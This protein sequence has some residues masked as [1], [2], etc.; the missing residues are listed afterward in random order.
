MQS[1]QQRGFVLMEVL[2]ALLVIAL[3]LPL[4]G[5]LLHWAV[6]T[7]QVSGALTVESYEARSVMERVVKD[8][9]EA[10]R[11][12]DIQGGSVLRL[13]NQAGEIIRYE[14]SGGIIYRTY[15]SAKTPLSEHV[16]GL[17][18]AFSDGLLQIS[19]GAGG[20]ALELMAGSR[21]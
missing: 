14:R 15:N 18:F 20:A 6:Q 12:V 4:L 7:N 3:A 10:A 21:L 13:E 11:V 5:Q 2:T 16:G 8:V 17:S 19:V 1:R 9:R